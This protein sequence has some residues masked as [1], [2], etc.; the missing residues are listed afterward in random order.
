MIWIVFALMTGAAV[1]AV[2]APLAIRR[3]QQDDKVADIAFFEAQIAEID[4]D[5]ADGRLDADDAEAARAEAARRL[6]RAGAA[7]QTQTGISRKAALFA[8]LAAIAFI[9]SLALSLYFRL[10]AADLPDMPLTARLDAQP[11][12]TD[13]AGAVARIEQHLRD[14]PEDGRGWEVVAP[15]FLRTGR[16]EDAIHAYA[17]AL[18][19]LGATAERYAALGEARMIVADG[20]VTPA[21][22]QDFAAASAL[23]P[24][25][26]MAR[27]Y[28]AIAA[29]QAG[30]KE[31][32]IEQFERLAADAPP[33][34][35]WLKSVKT[36]L[37]SLRGEA[38]PPAASPSENGPPVARSGPDSEQGQAIA[39]MPAGDQQKMIRMMV[40]RLAD[41]LAKNGDD[42]EGWLKLIRA[43]SVLAEPEKAK[44]ALADAHKALA[45]K[46]DD[47]ARIDALAKQLGVDG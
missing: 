22:A 2:L 42:V 5:R 14:H 24:A 15:Y 9:P 19:L 10:G 33:D 7:P 25:N 11:E 35:A 40:T 39:A 46:Q 4:R 6:L 13:I 28:L 38:A 47:I 12:R 27:Y 3:E 26:I 23:D 34:A 31:K 32:A 17:E 16:G 30:D 21:A 1:M 44:Q 41:R 45:A 18:R 36:Q 8:A 29:A 37:A 20:K 43:Y